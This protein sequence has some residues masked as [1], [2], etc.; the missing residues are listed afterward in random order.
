MEHMSAWNVPELIEVSTCFLQLPPCSISRELTLPVRTAIGLGVHLSFI[1]SLTMD[2]WSE[3]QM[4]KM[5]H[6]GNAPFREFMENY[7]PEGG[8]VKKQSIA[9]KYKTWA[10]AQY[11]EKVRRGIRSSSA[12]G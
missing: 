1:R 9:E 4:N 3:D 12:A 2:K 10:A 11:R 7:G 8:Y 5:R 6:G